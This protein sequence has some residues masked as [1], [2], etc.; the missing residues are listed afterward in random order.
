MVQCPHIVKG[1]E[2]IE[3]VELLSQTELLSR[4]GSGE[5]SDGYTLAAYAL[6]CAK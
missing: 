5:I 4:I 1:Y 2:G 3:S 6:Y